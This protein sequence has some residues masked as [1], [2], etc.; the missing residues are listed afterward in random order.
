MSLLI[1]L[2]TD[3]TILSWLWNFE[4][5]KHISLSFVTTIHLNRF[6]NLSSFS[7]TSVCLWKDGFGW[8]FNERRDVITSKHRVEWLIVSSSLPFPLLLRV[9][10]SNKSMKIC[11]LFYTYYYSWIR[12]PVDLSNRIKIIMEMKLDLYINNIRKRSWIWI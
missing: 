11:D 4:I 1:S 10:Q 8:R 12:V 2:M 5:I 9:S 7:A 3:T 6:V